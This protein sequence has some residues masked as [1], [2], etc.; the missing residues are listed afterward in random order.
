MSSP[1]TEAAAF[2]FGAATQMARYVAL[3]V[4]QW[5]GWFVLVC[6]VFHVLGLHPDSRS[7]FCPH[8]PAKCFLVAAWAR[9]PS[10]YRHSRRLPASPHIVCIIWLSFAIA[11]PAAPHHQRRMRQRSQRRRVSRPFVCFRLGL[12]RL[13][14]ARPR[15]RAQCAH[16]VRDCVRQAPQRHRR[17]LRLNPL[18]VFSVERK[19]HVSFGVWCDAVCGPS[20]FSCH[21]PRSCPA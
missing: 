15:T 3:Y 19:V 21:A 14:S 9:T 4:Q 13:R 16:T 6:G 11:P 8:R 17:G 10:D 12:R 7:V 1:W 5:V 20:G 18:L 2:G